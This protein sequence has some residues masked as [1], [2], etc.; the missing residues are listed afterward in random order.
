MKGEGQI[1][2]MREEFEAR[3]GFFPTLAQYKVIE[4]EYSAFGGD[5][6]AF[7]DAVK[8]NRDGL[9]EKIQRKADE[10]ALK[11]EHE[12]WKAIS[13]KDDEIGELK[14]RLER[15]QADL[16]RAEGWTAHEIS[17]M[18]QDDYNRLRSCGREMT[19]SEAWEYIAEEFGFNSDRV[20]ILRQI[21]TYQINKDKTNTRQNGK[22]SRPPV[23]DAT[24]YL[25]VRF[26]VHGAGGTWQYE[27]VN[28]ELYQ[29]YD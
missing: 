22:V 2:M 4:E 9:A 13:K 27:A 10:A 6:D 17:Q 26:D 28:G 20:Q 19:E 25:Y 5:K 14:T 8:E 15:L 3:T 16:D 29:Y 18:H 24:D 7:C 12:Q 11:A 23:Y 1:T 21:P